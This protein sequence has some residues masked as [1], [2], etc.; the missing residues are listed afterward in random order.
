MGEEGMQLC[1]RAKI[2]TWTK[3]RNVMTADAVFVSPY[4]H[5]CCTCVHLPTHIC[6][7]KLSVPLALIHS[8]W[9]AKHGVAYI[10]LPCLVKF[11]IYNILLYDYGMQALYYFFVSVIISCP[12]VIM[13]QYAKWTSCFSLP[14]V[15]WG[16]WPVNAWLS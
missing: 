7:P 9:M 1:K 5:T 2:Q 3:N 14:V 12:P 16:N 8:L 15:S 13:K 11:A 4:M 10:V 6:I